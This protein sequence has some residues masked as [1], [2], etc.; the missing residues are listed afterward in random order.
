M[1]HNIAK[2]EMHE[3]DGVR[4]R[5]CVHRK[6]ATRSFPGDRDEVPRAYRSVAQPVLV[7]GDMGSG[8]YVCAGTQKALEETFGSCCHGAG[9]AL[10]R[11][12][13]KKAQ[14]PS[15]LLAELAARGV[16]V[17]ARSKS[18]LAEEAPVAYKDVDV[19]VE[20]V[21]K[22]GIGRRVARIRPVGVV[23]G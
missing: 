12:A 7:P 9:R 10:S 13:A 4:T 1:C 5:L 21:E 8:S 18:T 20:T 23:K 19:V 6:G 3:V 15:E 14:S 11:K 2:F 16:E 22:A 17:M